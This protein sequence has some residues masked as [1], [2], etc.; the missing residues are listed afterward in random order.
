MS[1]DSDY[2]LLVIWEFRVREGMEARFEEAYNSVGVWAQFFQGCEGYVR[3]DLIRDQKKAR[4]YVTLDFWRSA[5]AY[6]TFRAQKS[7]GYKQIDAR[8]EEFTE[9]EVELGR[10]E[11]C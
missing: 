10:F 4:R 6:K 5:E 7:E 3:T 11:R 2:G 9:S 8:C 1:V